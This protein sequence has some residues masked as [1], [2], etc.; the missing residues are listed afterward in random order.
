MVRVIDPKY[1]GDSETA[2]LTALAEIWARGC[3]F[4]VAG[5]QMDG[6]FRTLDEVAIPKGSNPCSK[7]IPEESFRADVSSTELRGRG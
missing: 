3:R 4:L 5:R 1:Y 2:M 7:A 6:A